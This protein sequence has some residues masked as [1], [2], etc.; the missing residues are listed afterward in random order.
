MLCISSACTMPWAERCRPEF[1]DD[2]RNGQSTQMFTT[3]IFL[4]HTVQIPKK[5]TLNTVKF[6]SLITLFFNINKIARVL[7]FFFFFFLKS[8]THEKF[9]QKINKAYA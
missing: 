4:H 7:F 1:F 8:I 6:I 9:T 3:S 2:A 5:G